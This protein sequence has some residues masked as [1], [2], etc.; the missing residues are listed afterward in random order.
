MV[1]GP[2]PVRTKDRAFEPRNAL[3]CGR[4][5]P[6]LP[7]SQSGIP[8]DGRAA[9]TPRLHHAVRAHDGDGVVGA[10]PSYVAAAA[11]RLEREAPADLNPNAESA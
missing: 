2:C 3:H 10:A 8:R 6:L 11:L 4:T 5:L 7:C 9:E 1:I